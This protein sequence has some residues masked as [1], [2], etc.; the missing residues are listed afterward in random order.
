MKN[1]G[2]RETNDGKGCSS[3][4]VIIIGMQTMRLQANATISISA[5]DQM[6]GCDSNPGKICHG[7]GGHPANR[8]KGR[9][10]R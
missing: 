4:G 5:I 10:R 3:G 7:L 2:A 1:V 9:R 8:G 6:M